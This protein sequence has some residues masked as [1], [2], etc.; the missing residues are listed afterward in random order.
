[1]TINLISSIVGAVMFIC[2][3]PA[4]TPVILL[5][6]AVYAGNQLGAFLLQPGIGCRTA[7]VS[8]AQ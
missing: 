3:L 8:L 6:L 5:A 4:F 7:Q 2:L 1:M